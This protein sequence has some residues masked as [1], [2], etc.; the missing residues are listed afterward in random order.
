MKTD[1]DAI[2]YILKVHE[3]Y[4]EKQLYGQRTVYVN[5]KRDWLQ[6]TKLLFVRRSV[7]IG[8]GIIDRFISRDE[9]QEQD[10]K[11]CLENNCYGKIE[12]AKL[13]RYYPPVSIESTNL[14]SKNPITLHGT[15]LA[16]SEALNIEHLARARLVIL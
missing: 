8:S 13:A 15:S 12:F 14:A 1:S 10:K 6:N 7:F 4:V 16:L 11:R 5:I 9:L 3:R 2:S